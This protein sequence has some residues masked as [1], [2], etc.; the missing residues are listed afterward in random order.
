MTERDMEKLLDLIRDM[1]RDSVNSNSLMNA[2]QR[3]VKIIGA[4]VVS[5]SGTDITVTLAGT[6]TNIEV[7]NFTGQTLATNDMVEVVIK[8]GNYTNA[9]IGWKR[10]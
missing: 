1:I 7:P 3:P 8:N 4:E 5:V 10:P 2:P 6:T 9:F